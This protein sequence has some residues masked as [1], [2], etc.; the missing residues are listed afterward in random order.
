M[1]RPQ[2]EARHA[3]ASP[4]VTHEYTLSEKAPTRGLF[5]FGRA[6]LFLSFIRSDWHNYN[7]L[8]DIPQCCTAIITLF[9]MMLMNAC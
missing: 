9:N 8:M 7:V 5:L 6:L 2:P 4:A 3:K 1:R